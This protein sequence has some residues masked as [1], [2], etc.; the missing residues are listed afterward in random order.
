MA[1]GPQ[2]GLELVDRLTDDPALA[3]YAELAAVRGTLLNQL[4]RCEEAK[5]EFDRAAALTDNQRQRELYL[6]QAN[7]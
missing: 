3:R 7:P 1:E 2:R 5:A 4:H 6:R